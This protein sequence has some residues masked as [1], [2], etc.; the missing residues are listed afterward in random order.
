MY[1][2][3][4]LEIKLIEFERSNRECFNKLK[5]APEFRETLEK[6]IEA[7]LALADLALIGI[8]ERLGNRGDEYVEQLQGRIEYWRRKY[9]EYR[10]SFLKQKSKNKK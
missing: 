9:K 5:L 3:E 1:N 7:N 8:R 10:E 6:R 4:Q 2:R